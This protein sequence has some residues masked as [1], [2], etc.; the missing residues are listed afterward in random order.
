MFPTVWSKC[1][2]NYSLSMLHPVD[3]MLI[4]LLMADK[5]SAWKLD[6]NLAAVVAILAR[7]SPY[8]A[9]TMRVTV[10]VCGANLLLGLGAEDPIIIVQTQ[11]CSDIFS[12]WHWHIHYLRC[13]S[14]LSFWWLWVLGQVYTY[15]YIYHL[16][17]TLILLSLKCLYSIMTSLDVKTLPTT[18]SHPPFISHSRMRANLWT[19]ESSG[20]M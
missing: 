9:S 7:V 2:R 3:Y 12:F 6:Q 17:I 14:P 13:C 4:K 18:P 16:Y 8:L 20:D 11:L 10:C 5:S 19:V 1:D 15:S